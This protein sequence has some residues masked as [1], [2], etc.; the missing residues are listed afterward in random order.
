MASRYN[1]HMPILKK[2]AKKIKIKK[3]LELGS[4]GYSTKLFIDKNFFPDL[5]HLKS[6]E[7]DE[8]WFRMLLRDIEDK[9]FDYIFSPNGIHEEIDLIQ[10]DN[11]DLIFIDS[12]KNKAE[13]IAVIKSV[14]KRKPKCIVVIHDCDYSEYV[15]AADFENS[16]IH[17]AMADI[18]IFWNGKN[19]LLEDLKNGI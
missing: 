11:F 9:R 15:K 6:Y 7:D 17:K 19:K 13:R 1:S 2:I 14:A 10:L 18:G 16:Y 3:I 4:G 5:V 8:S 12:G